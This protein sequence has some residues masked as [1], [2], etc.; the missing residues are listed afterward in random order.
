MTQ[1]STYSQTFIY[2]IV[3]RIILK[4]HHTHNAQNLT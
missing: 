1:C 4:P 3:G 2:V